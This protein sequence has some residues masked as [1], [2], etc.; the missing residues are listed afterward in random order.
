MDSYNNQSD[1]GYSEQQSGGFLSGLYSSRRINALEI[2][3]ILISIAMLAGVFWWGFVNQQAINRDKQRVADIGNVIQALDEFYKNTSL[4]PSQRFY[5]KA[6][7]S[8]SLN[9][10]DFEFTLRNYLTGKV[11]EVES[12][13]YINPENFPKDRWGEYSKTFIQR[14]VTYRCSEKL[15]SNTSGDSQVYRDG[16]D[17]CSFN[18]KSNYKKCY[19]YTA[20][21]SGDTYQLSYYKEE[22]GKFILYEKFREDQIK[23][24]S[25]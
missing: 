8:E 7:C 9:E 23:I 14:K 22:T 25:E 18:K 19:L 24:S 15:S 11:P 3:L 13:I 6:P 20:S 16:Y 4:I 1:Y 21:N 12:H 2:G 5:P 17:S 10:V